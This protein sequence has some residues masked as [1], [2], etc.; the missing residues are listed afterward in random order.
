MMVGSAV[1]F[2]DPAQDFN[3]YV[4]AVMTVSFVG[5]LF[6]FLLGL[7]RLGFVT[8]ILSETLITAFTAGSAFNI[9]ASQL[10]HFWGVKTEKDSFLLILIDL[11]Q[12]EKVV[13]F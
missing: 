11:F 3:D 10:K 5:G 1:G 2:L 9:A 6:L 8:S 7:L 12:P 4:G 13:H